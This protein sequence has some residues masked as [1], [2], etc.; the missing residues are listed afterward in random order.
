MTTTNDD[1]IPFMQ[2]LL[3][4]HFLLL[5]IGVASPGLIYILWGII[6]IMTVP[7]AK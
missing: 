3:D 1:D 4:N 6:D 7:L 5:F 2:K